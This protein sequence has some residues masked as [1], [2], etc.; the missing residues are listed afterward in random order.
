MKNLLKVVLIAGC[1]VFAGT[2]AKAQGKTG[3]IN[4]NAVI[5]QMPDTK[6]ISSQLQTYQQT[7]IT[8]LQSMQNE[9]QTKGAD[10]ESKR[11]TMTDAV[12]TQR[13][14]ELTDL[15]KRIQD[16]QTTAQGKVEAEKDRLGKPLLDKVKAAITAVA[17]EKGYAY[18]IDSSQG[19][20]IV[21]PEADDLMPAVKIKLGL[22]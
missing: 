9:Y 8:Q 11:A 15:Q 22:K 1:M 3:Y 19:I 2:L 18:V 7:F 16:Y 6:V 5:D 17:K 20:F 10:Y 4:F 21:S 12:R 13:E 14:A